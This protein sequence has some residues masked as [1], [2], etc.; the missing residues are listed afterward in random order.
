M[1]V[2]P[3]PI[4]VLISGSGTNLQ[5]IIDQLQGDEAPGE[6]KAVI[7]NRPDAYG[8][9]RAT[10]AGIPAQ[11]WITSDMRIAPNSIGP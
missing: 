6:I 4:V 2:S 7:S 11:C 9:E 10:K 5:A 3:L 8:L 1:S